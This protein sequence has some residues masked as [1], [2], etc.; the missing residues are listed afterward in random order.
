MAVLGANGTMGSLSG[1]IF[2][3]AGIPCLFFARS[4]EKAREGIERAV[5]QARSDVLRDFIAPR[6]YDELAGEAAGCD[7]ILEAVAEDLDLKREYYR[8]IDRHRKPGGIVTTISSSL[9]IEELAAEC[10]ADFQA[11]FAGVHFFN[12]PGRLPAN[13]IIFHPRSSKEL[14][15]FLPDFCRKALRR[16]NIVACDRPGFAGNR[17]GFQ[18]LNEAAIYAEK[19]GTET[20]DYLL[21][22]YTG[23]AMPPLET[24][25]LVGLDV[26]REVVQNIHDRTDDERRDSFV[27]PPYLRKMIDNRWLGRKSG[28]LGG[29]Y[30]PAENR[31]RLALE[32]GRLDHARPAGGKNDLVEKVKE[33][34]HDGGYREAIRLI[35]EDWSE[36]MALVKHFLLGYVAYSYA[37]IGEVTPAEAGI[38]GIDRVMAYGFSWLPPSAWVDF[39]GGPRETVELLDRCRLPVPRPLANAPEGRQCRIPEVTRYLCAL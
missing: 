12:P 38:D 11:H 2:A 7:W 21:G 18:L 22:P 17:I 39:F 37:R 34:I 24:I 23:R 28:R 29:F 31:E 4:I 26:H 14:R 20:I 36:E 13:E 33:H 3:Q 1:G 8:L 19:Y 9:S 25:D 32:P 6:T 35:K 27:L 15:A 5:D 10:S 16:V 30:R